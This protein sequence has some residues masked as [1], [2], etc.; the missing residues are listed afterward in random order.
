[1]LQGSNINR[2]LKKNIERIKLKYTGKGT[3]NL[4]KRK[5]KTEEKMFKNQPIIH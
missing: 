5:R 4:K 2:Y 3:N 1:M